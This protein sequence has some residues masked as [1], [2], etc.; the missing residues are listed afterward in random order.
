VP[1]VL[2]IDKST[3]LESIDELETRARGGMVTS[4]FKV[5]D[6]LAQAGFMVEVLSDIEQAGTTPAGVVW[7]K[8][9]EGRYDILVC[10]RGIGE[11]YD[12]I[13]AARRVL[14][15][16]DLPHAGF[17]PNPK[18]IRAF[19]CVVFMSSYAEKIWRT[20]YRTI[21]KSATIPNGIDRSLFYYDPEEKDWDYLIYGSAPNRGADKLPFLFDA[22]NAAS[23]RHV[24]MNAFTN[25]SVLHPNEADYE[26]DY[27]EFGESGVSLEDPLPQ[28]EWAEQL[29][30]AGLM[31][32]PTAYPEI[33]SN[34]VLQS[35]A[36]GVPVITTGNLG[37]TPEW[38]KHGKNGML[39]DWMPHDYMIHSLDMIRNAS[40]VLAD[41]GRQKKMAYRASV[42]PNIL[43]WEEV[44]RK[45]EKL[46]KRL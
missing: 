18:T 20:F 32:L 13:D 14:W 5:T 27:G 17:I 28:H 30:A 16:H 34:T 31:I 2:F 41:F 39:T 33:C 40:E 3:K 26:L 24:W 36:C 42:T 43:S 29:R 1:R 4:L 6:H 22:I 7:E 12:H 37:A 38:V 44:G 9:P 35:L 21:G 11:G 25:M 10:N 15:T 8:L 23:D 19:D 45:W 46:L